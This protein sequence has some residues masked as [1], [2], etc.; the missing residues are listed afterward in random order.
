[1]K[2]IIIKISAICLIALTFISCNDDLPTPVASF[3]IEKDTIIDAKKVRIPVTVADTINPIFFVY[4]GE[5]TFNS[6]W[7]GDRFKA[8]IRINEAVN[9]K[10]VSKNVTYYISQDYGTRVD[11]VLMNYFAKKDTAFTQAAVLYQGIALPFGTKEIQ[12]T[13]KS[14]GNLVVTWISKNANH[15]M[16]NQEIS[17]KHILVK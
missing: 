6:V 4:K 11:T 5:A 7:P 3:V 12:Y 17:Q 16:I 15:K 9:N 1:M 8:T 2:N 13:F 10:P 14:K